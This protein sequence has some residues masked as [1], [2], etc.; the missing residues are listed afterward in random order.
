MYKFTQVYRIIIQGVH[1]P[2]LTWGSLLL[3]Q[4]TTSNFRIPSVLIF[5][6]VHEKKITP[7]EKN[8][9]DCCNLSYIF[10]KSNYVVRFLLEKR[11]KKVQTKFFF[12]V[13]KQL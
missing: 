5:K 10:Q 2:F 3:K 8:K 1:P 7:Q 12:I 11:L 6:L 4:F 9:V 13:P